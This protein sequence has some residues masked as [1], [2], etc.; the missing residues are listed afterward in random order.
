MWIFLQSLST[1]ETVI[2][3]GRVFVYRFIFCFKYFYSG[4]D[5]SEVQGQIAAKFLNIKW[6]L[7]PVAVFFGDVTLSL[8]PN[9][10]PCIVYHCLVVGVSLLLVNSKAVF[11]SPLFIIIYLLLS[12]YLSL[13]IKIQ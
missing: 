8:W 3:R 2:S 10:C 9:S 11:S 12:I 4:T 13:D 1:K 7:G 6:R 5:C